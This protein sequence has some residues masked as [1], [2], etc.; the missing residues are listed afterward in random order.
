MTKERKE[1]NQPEQAV[2]TIKKFLPSGYFC[3]KEE[4]RKC[5]GNARNND[6]WWWSKPAVPPLTLLQYARCTA[7]LQVSGQQTMKPE[8]ATVKLKQNRIEPNV[9]IDVIC[10]WLAVGMIEMR[11]AE[12]NPNRKIGSDRAD[13]SKPDVGLLRVWLGLL[14]H[15]I[16]F[17]F[18]DHC[19]DGFSV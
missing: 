13:N 5:I 4:R 6:L 16:K 14:P 2:Q 7:S 11:S 12:P 9:L 10:I 19:P 18:R 3:Q 15:K 17:K 1:R 8:L